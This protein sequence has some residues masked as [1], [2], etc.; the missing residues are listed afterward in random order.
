MRK[1]ATLRYKAI[2]KGKIESLYL[3]YYPPLTGKDG[4]TCWYEFL[5]MERYKSPENDVERRYNHDVEE[6]AEA[7]RCERYLMLVR[8]DYPFSCYTGLRKEGSMHIIIKKTKVEVRLPL[9]N[10][11]MRIIGNPK[12]KGRIFPSLTVSILNEQIPKLIRQAGIRKCITFH[13]FRYTFA[14]MLLDRG[15]D[16]YTIAHLLGHKQVS[17]TQCYV[18]PSDKLCQ[19]AIKLLDK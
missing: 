1:G 9:S 16:I 14:Q 6:L 17:S 11:A 12:Q 18:R 19:Q 5:H 13:C 3:Q 7:I 8:K 2:S 15:V 10:K 4:K